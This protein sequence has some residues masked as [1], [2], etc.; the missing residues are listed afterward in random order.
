MASNAY[1]L[2]KFGVYVN[3]MTSTHLNLFMLMVILWKTK[4]CLTLQLMH[5]ISGSTLSRLRS[6]NKSHQY[7][8]AAPDTH[9]V[10]AAVLR[11]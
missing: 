7:A 5:I 3:G 6:A 11:R 4:I 9:Y 1:F 10:R 8:P 2:K